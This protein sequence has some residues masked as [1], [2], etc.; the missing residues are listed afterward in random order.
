MDRTTPGFPVLHYL[1]EFVQAHVHWVD[2]AI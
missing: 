2:D 1:S